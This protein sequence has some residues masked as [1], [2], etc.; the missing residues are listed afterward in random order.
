MRIGIGFGVGPFR[1]SQT[2]FRTSA[3]RRRRVHRRR[4]AGQHSG[5]YYTGIVLAWLCFGP[6]IVAFYAA[7]WG[8]RKHL[9]QQA[10]VGRHRLAQA[11]AAPPPLPGYRQPP[12]DAPMLYPPRPQQVPP[13]VPPGAYG[14]GGTHN[15]R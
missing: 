5:W 7:R 2:L 10:A 13:P 15:I 3:R 11:P 14:T 1:V 12:V 6:I 9:E 8:W 4:R